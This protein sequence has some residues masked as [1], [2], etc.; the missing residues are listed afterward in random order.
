MPAF[1]PGLPLP[2]PVPVP[3]PLPP[4]WLHPCHARM[5]AVDS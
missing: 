4:P 1:L 5:R 2:L 3:P